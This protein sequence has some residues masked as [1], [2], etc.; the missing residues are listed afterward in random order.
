MLDEKAFIAE[1][2]KKVEKELAERELNELTF[3]KGELVKLSQ[4]KAES[5]G[6]L[7]LELKNLI[8]RMENRTRILKTNAKS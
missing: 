5:L 6:S 2:K 1:L 8:Q 4:K 7:Q 3:W